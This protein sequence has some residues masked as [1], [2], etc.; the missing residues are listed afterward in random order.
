MRSCRPSRTS[1]LSCISVSLGAVTGLPRAKVT[2]MFTHVVAITG[3]I[4]TGKPTAMGALVDLLADRVIG[5]DDQS[6]HA[7][8]GTRDRGLAHAPQQCH[9]D[10]AG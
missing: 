2:V 1:H 5:G 4:G 8:T 6:R 7:S 3:L 9:A 10:G